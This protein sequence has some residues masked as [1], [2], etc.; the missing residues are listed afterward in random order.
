[1]GKMYF[2]DEI[3]IPRNPRNAEFQSIWI[4]QN[5]YERGEKGMKIHINFAVFN[6]QNTAGI[7]AAY[8]Y[9]RDGDP[10]PDFNDRYCTADGCVAIHQPIYPTRRFAQ[11]SDFTLFMPYS[12]L[13]VI[14]NSM[15]KFQL[16][17]WIDNKQPS[18]FDRYIETARSEFFNFYYK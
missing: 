2:P 6:S 11:F 1:M 16:I 14:H 10:L 7:V 12:E 17:I 4:E 9:Y 8:F 3:Q 5:V 13:H 18:P 15:L